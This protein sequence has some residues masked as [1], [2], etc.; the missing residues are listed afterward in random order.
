MSVTPL[1]IISF[2]NSQLYFSILINQPTESQPVLIEDINFDI[3]NDLS[4]FRSVDARKG[5]NEILVLR[6]GLGRK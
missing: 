1:R 6:I 2:L 4:V 3:F 5:A